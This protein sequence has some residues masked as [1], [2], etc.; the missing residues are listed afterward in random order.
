LGH[1]QQHNGD[2]GDDEDEVHI[3][4]SR[5]CGPAKML[6]SLLIIFKDYKHKCISSPAFDRLLAQRSVFDSIGPRA[7]RQGRLESNFYD[8][9]KRNS[10]ITPI[11]ILI[12]K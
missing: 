12:I 5:P 11:E 4:F 9:F 3:L 2:V 8:I 10:F 6:F 1:H 7:Q